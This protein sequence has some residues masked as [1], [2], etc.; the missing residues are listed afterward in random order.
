MT[1]SKKIILIIV[2]LIIVVFLGF[3][4]VAN[5]IISDA[6]ALPIEKIDFSQIADGQY[7]GNYKIFPVKVSV[8]TTVQNGKI[9]QIEIVEHFNGK[10]TSAEK[11]VDRI[12]EKQSLQ[13]DSISGAT[14]SSI[15]IKKA[16]EDSLLE[17]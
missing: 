13:V 12:I 4:I 17:K 5:K 7:I 8:K 3:K 16:I 15:A 1:K 10:G 14:M 9:T 6:K 11:I 2:A